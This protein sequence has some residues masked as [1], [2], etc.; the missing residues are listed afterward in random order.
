MEGE[1]PRRRRNWF[2]RLLQWIFQLLLAAVRF[3]FSTLRLLYKSSWKTLIAT[4][5]ID[6]LSGGKLSAYQFKLL[7]CVVNAQ[8]FRVCV[9]G[10]V[11]WFKTGEY[12]LDGPYPATLSAMASN[13]DLPLNAPILSRLAFC[14]AGYLEWAVTG[15]LPLVCL[16]P[17]FQVIYDTLSGNAFILQMA[18]ICRAAVHICLSAVFLHVSLRTVGFCFL[19]VLWLCQCPIRVIVS[20]TISLC[21]VWFSM[22]RYGSRGVE[23]VLDSLFELLLNYIKHYPA[24][25]FSQACGIL[26]TQVED[27]HPVANM[28]RFLFSSSTLFT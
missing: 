9:T 6:L 10:L 11:Q 3:V 1:A 23:I 27:L 19:M 26:S 22:L 4:M 14:V 25:T 16:H 24:G 2:L 13:I 21:I 20:G 18:N 8:Y 28:V 15:A 5:V 17:I 12:P 7:A